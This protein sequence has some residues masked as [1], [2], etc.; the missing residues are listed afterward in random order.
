MWSSHVYFVSLLTI[1]VILLLSLLGRRQPTP[2]SHAASILETLPLTIYYTARHFSLT[3]SPPS[4]FHA[5]P[6]ATQSISHRRLSTVTLHTAKIPYSH[7]MPNHN[8]S[9]THSTLNGTRAITLT[10]HSNNLIYSLSHY[11]HNTQRISHL[12]IRNLPH[13]YSLSR[14]ITPALLHPHDRRPT[15]TRTHTISTTPRPVSL[16]TLRR[17]TLL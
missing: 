9:L 16:L 11:N 1:H 17:T 7:P 3:K 6:T 12:Y 10:N 5:P 4:N 13:T 14:T 15:N 2:P 8:I